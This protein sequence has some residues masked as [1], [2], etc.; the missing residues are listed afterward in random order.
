MTIRSATA[1]PQ[2]VCRFLPAGDTGLTVEFGDV[3]DE[4]L[5]RLVVTFDRQVRQA[6]IPGVIE[7]IPSYRSLLVLYEPQVIGA[8][9]LTDRLRALVPDHPDDQKDIRRW[10]IP[11]TYG[12]A[13]GMDLD[14]IAKS[15]D[16]TTGD[17]IALHSGALYRVYMIG[18]APGFSYLGG[19]P[20]ALRTPRRADPR[21]TTPAGSVSL[22]GEQAAVSSLELPSGWHMLGRTPVRTFDL[23]RDRPFLLDV[24]DLVRFVP[25]GAAEFERLDTLA[26]SGEI[27]AEFEVT[28]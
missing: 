27:V 8:G 13:Y 21:L 4:H 18:F 5:N 1:A 24:G 3:I 6:D 10:Q 28:R 7:T 2:P 22:G 25:V 16:L 12:G 15:H 17:V 9:A 14:F 19:L 26:A 23:R 11:V 20:A